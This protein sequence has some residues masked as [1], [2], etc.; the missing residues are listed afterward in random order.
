MMSQTDGKQFLY[1]DMK[2]L[3][4]MFGQRISS[5]INCVS[6]GTVQTFYSETQTA[7]ININYMKRIKGKSTD[8]EG[9]TIDTF[10]SYPMLVNCPV[11]WLFGGSGFLTFPIAAGD[12]CVVL[13][14]DRDIDN[15]H[16]SGSSKSVPNSVR[17]H[18]ISAGVAIVGLK[19]LVSKKTNYNASAVQLGYGSTVITM[20]ASGATIST[21]GA[22]NVSSTGNTS[23]TVGGNLTATVTGSATVAATG[24][25]TISGSTVSII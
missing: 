3:L 19:S 5:S 7:D 17:L 9:K 2:T 6:I 12:E 23:V 11:V 4:D 24:A 21:S 14:C 25:V 10:E 8:K 13:F 22:L 1:P 16:A 15:W 20:N 18:D